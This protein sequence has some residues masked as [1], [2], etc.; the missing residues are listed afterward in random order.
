MLD[1]REDEILLFITNYISK[2]TTEVKIF[3]SYFNVDGTIMA[4]RYYYTQ[5][6]WSNLG[7]S[8]QQIDLF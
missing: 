2:N 8:C 4:T 1:G 5:G 7:T 6:S 3:T